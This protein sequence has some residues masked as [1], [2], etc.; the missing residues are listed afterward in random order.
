MVTTSRLSQKR[1][2]QPFA[3]GYEAIGLPARLIGVPFPAQEFF[4]TESLGGV[5]W[6]ACLS[7]EEP[8]RRYDPAP[9]EVLCRLNLAG[10][11]MF[12]P[13]SVAAFSN[14]AQL[15]HKHLQ[16]SEGVLI[17]CDMGIERTGTL[18]GVVLALYGIAPDIIARA[19]ANIIEVQQPGWTD[20]KFRP[21]LENAICTVSSASSTCLS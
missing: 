4:R 8:R 16:K 21:Q 3:N 1:L 14:T 2:L 12:S 17:H 11:F 6:I 7:S 19:L 13:T 5:R 15:V 20:E 10:P 18:F 9:L